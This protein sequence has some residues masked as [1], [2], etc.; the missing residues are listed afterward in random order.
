MHAWQT[1]NVDIAKTMNFFGIKKL[2]DPKEVISE[3]VKNRRHMKE[4]R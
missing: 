2:K 1:L 3:I 4:E